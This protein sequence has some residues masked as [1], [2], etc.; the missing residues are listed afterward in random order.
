MRQLNKRRMEDFTVSVS[1]FVALVNET[2]D[3]AFP[4]VTIV[5][6]LANFRVSKNRWVYF[7][8]KD[9]DA[10][11]KFF[12]TVYM[13]PGP[14]EDGMVLQVRGTPRMHPLYGFSVT[15]QNIR[16]VGEGAI[17]RASDLLQAKLA[18]EGLFDAERK[19]TLPVIP[20]RIG[21]IASRESAAYIDFMKIINARWG[22]LVI[23]F[24]DV[25]VQGDVAPA[26][27]VSAL[28]QFNQ[29]QSPPE[30][31]VITRGGGSAED[32]QAF[33]TEQVTRA[34]A[35]SRI[36]TMVAIGHERDISLAELAADVRASTPSNAAE[37]LV[38]DRQQVLAHVQLTA[39]NLHT[40]ITEIIT[41]EK[42][43]L[44]RAVQQST[45][46]IN[47][48]LQQSQ[49]TAG[50]YKRLLSVLSPEAALKRGYALV[51]RGKQVVRSVANVAAQDGLDIQLVDGTIHA[52][53]I[54]VTQGKREK[55][56]GT[57]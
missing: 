33:S 46:A 48:L 8:L 24:I 57:S 32:L 3:I 28:Q 53:V 49:E 14:L 30:V 34:V 47:R 12:G 50:R 10:S 29:L 56:D 45:Q 20:E 51:R 40:E 13:L 23:E 31:V 55:I 21:L 43:E 44:D 7:D 37:L 22:G 1:E 17:K 4:A 26:Q 5:G 35:L 27:V 52:E 15:A 18:A 36:P 54:Q 16:P 38:P 42:D 25:Q 9:E 41:R 39:R 6:E 19:R 11:V 2:F